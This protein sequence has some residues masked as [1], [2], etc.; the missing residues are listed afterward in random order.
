MRVVIVVAA[1]WFASTAAA[2]TPD[3]KKLLLQPAQVGK[4]YAMVPA[5]GGKGVAGDRTMNLCGLDYP[6]ERLR[7]SRVQVN[8]LKK[9][10]PIGITNE[11]VTYKGTGAQQAIR[12]ALHHATSCPNHPIDTGVKGLPKLTFHVTQVRD[13]RLLKGYLAVRI[14]VKG[15]VK[16]RAVAQTSYAVYQQRG[17]VLSGVYSFGLT[18][19]GQLALCLHAAEQ[20]ARNLRRGGSGSSSA[21]TA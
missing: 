4:G 10:T 20:S 2:A 12:E 9:K 19:K 14:D 17:K 16:G 18:P 6:S 13:P 15:T 7:V 11:V 21:P 8:Y 5:A 1:L 3:V